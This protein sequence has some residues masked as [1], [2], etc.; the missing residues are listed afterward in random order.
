MT[1]TIDPASTVRAFWKVSCS[2]NAS[3]QARRSHATQLGGIMTEYRSHRLASSDDTCGGAMRVARTRIP[4]WGI[5]AARRAG[6]TALRIREMYP[7]LSERDVEDALRYADR[8]VDEMDRLI[9][10]SQAD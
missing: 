4:V 1:F 7:S 8:H 6:A 10:A 2:G 9:A 5:E 3:W